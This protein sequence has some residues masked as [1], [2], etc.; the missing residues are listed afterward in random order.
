MATYIGTERLGADMSDLLPFV[1]R[2]KT[3]RDDNS[4]H[5]EIPIVGHLAAE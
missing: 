1:A 5:L 3:S 4:V 2:L